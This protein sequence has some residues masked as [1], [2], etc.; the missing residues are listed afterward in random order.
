MATITESF[1]KADSSTLGPDLTWTELTGDTQIVGNRARCVSTYSG[2]A[3]RADSDLASANHYAQIAVYIDGS[4]D[5]RGAGPIVR[6]DSS[7][8]LTCYLLWVDV[9]SAGNFRYTFYKVVGGS[10]TAI[11]SSTSVTVASG[12]VFRLSADG[13]TLSA[14][15]NGTLLGTQTDSSIS[16]GT[17]CGFRLY[18][19]GGTPTVT[20]VEIDNFEAGD[21]TAA[22]SLI[23]YQPAIA[24]LLVR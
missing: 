20:A 1:N 23:Y 6:K 13:T 4:D 18:S 21:L 8:T 17:R 10:F 11:G 24:P 14:Y 3:N 22:A 12:D 16:T 2:S 15:K 7:A 19:G 9:A 5:G